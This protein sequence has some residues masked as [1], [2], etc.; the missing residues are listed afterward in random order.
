MRVDDFL[1]NVR[2]DEKL[3]RYIFSSSHIRTSDSTVK[4]EAFSP[5]RDLRLS[6]TRH[7]DLNE[8][9]LW[10]LGRNA[11]IRRPDS[12]LYG[13]ADLQAIV[14]R[15]Q[16]LD[17]ES[18][19]LPDNQEHAVVI[20]WPEDKPLQKIIALELARLASYLPNPN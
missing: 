6:V 12:K 1:I 11:G 15:N 16:S 4:P 13:R 9:N 2:D 7:L 5:P 17:V 20:K 10:R 14:P 19:P 18:D 8:E 3:A